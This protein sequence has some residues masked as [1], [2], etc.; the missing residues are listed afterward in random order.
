MMGFK[1]LRWA[2]VGLIVFLLT[3]GLTGVAVA[4]SSEEDVA[5]DR[6]NTRLDAAVEAGKLTSDEADEIRER[7][8]ENGTH[9]GKGHWK[10]RS[11]EAMG[12]RLDA[13]VEAG[14]LTSDEADEIRERI[15]ENGTHFSKK[16]A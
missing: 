5:K 2:Y 15:A 7:I 11:L 6:I 3:I 16:T 4:S 8:A 14:K 13:A 9:F 1:G 12:A 10:L